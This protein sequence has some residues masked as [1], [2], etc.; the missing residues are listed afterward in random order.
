MNSSLNTLKSAIIVLAGLGLFAILNMSTRTDPTDMITNILQLPQDNNGWSIN[1]TQISASLS[2]NNPVEN[3]FRNT[4]T[5]TNAEHICMAKNIYFEARNESL[6]GMIAIAQVTITRMQDP[7]WPN[8]ICS[9]VYQNKQFSWY[10]DGLSDRPK[11]HNK[12]AE[13][14]LITTA[15][16][17]PDMIIQDITNGATHYH[18]DY[19]LPYWTKYMVKQVK[20]DTHIFYQDQVITKA[21]L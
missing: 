3:L 9:V 1:A 5:Y 2:I 19:V 18:A 8:T 16:L 13:I 4:K 11:D 10:S 6:A 14:I 12:F 7:R 21:S 20:I 17:D 15:I